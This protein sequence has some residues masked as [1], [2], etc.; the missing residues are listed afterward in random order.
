MGI[1]V[2]GSDC[3]KTCERNGCH[4]RAEGKN[5][6]SGSAR[7]KLQAT[8]G[9]LHFISLMEIDICHEVPPQ[10]WAESSILLMW[11]EMRREYPL[12]WRAESSCRYQCCLKTHKNKQYVAKI[13]K[14]AIL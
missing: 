6:S 8:F 1:V 5:T 2:N 13:K 10:W 12:E 11:I 14:A 4:E 9:I 7:V 3:S